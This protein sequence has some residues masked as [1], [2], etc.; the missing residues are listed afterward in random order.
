M[1]IVR[2]R[3][4]M[5]RRRAWSALPWLG[6]RALGFGGGFVLPERSH[7]GAVVVCRDPRCPI[8]A[9]AAREATALAG[10]TACR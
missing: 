5:L 7:A 4:R 3:R 2:R 8:C 6:V 10:Q 9:R 1:V